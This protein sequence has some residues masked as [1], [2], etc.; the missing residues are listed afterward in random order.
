MLHTLVVK[1][2]AA[3]PYAKAG[4]ARVREMVAE[5]NAAKARGKKGGKGKDIFIYNL[6]EYLRCVQTL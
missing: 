4:R 6:F 2:K 5:R 1:M 3:P